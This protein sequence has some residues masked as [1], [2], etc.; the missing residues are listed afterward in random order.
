MSSHSS[1]SKSVFYKIFK[2]SWRGVLPFRKHS[3]HSKYDHCFRYQIG[4]QKAT[5]PY[6]T[7]AQNFQA[8]LSKE[9]TLNHTRSSIMI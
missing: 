8:S 5:E 3:Q 7:D 9:Y 6:L 4:R 2:S 1:A